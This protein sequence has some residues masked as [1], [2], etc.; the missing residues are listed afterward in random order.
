TVYRETLNTFSIMDNLAQVIIIILP[1]I[2]S[3][4]FASHLF[5]KERLIDKLN[6]VFFILCCQIILVAYAL[7][8]FNAL[9]GNN[10]LVA[11]VVLFLVSLVLCRDKRMSISF[12]VDQIRLYARLL[13]YHL[14][15]NKLLTVFACA[16]IVSLLWRMFLILYVP[17]NTYDSMTYHLARVAYWLQHQSLNS[18]YTNNLRQTVF[19]LNAELLLLWTM[20]ASKIDC[21][22]GFVQFFCYLLSG[23]LIYKCL[24]QYLKT[25]IVPSLSVTFVWYSL[26]EIVL[27]ST[28]TQNDLV[29]SYFL[30]F[31]L[32]YFLCG[33]TDAKKYLPVSAIALAIAIGTKI[34]AVFFL[35]PFFMVLG[36]FSMSS[37]RHAKRMFLWGATF[38]A[39]FMVF[40]APIFIRNFFKYH[41]PLVYGAGNHSLMISRSM[42]GFVTKLCE[43][44]Y[45]ITTNQSGLDVYAPGYAH[46]YNTFVSKIS[47]TMFALL[48]MLFGYPG[49]PQYPE[50]HRFEFKDWSFTFT[51]HEDSAF[52]GTIGLV[53]VLLVS[54]IFFAVAIKLLT[55]K[56]KIDSRYFVFAFLFTGYL[57]GLSYFLPWDPWMSRYMITGVLAG[58]PVLAL[59]FNSKI[60]FLKRV[61]SMVVVYSLMI[62][63]PATLL[64]EK[65]PLYKLRNDKLAL[66]CIPSLGKE[67]IV[68]RFNELVPLHT[69]IGVVVSENSRDYLLFGEKLQRLLVPLNQEAIKKQKFDFIVAI[70]NVLEKKQELK[71]SIE[72]DYALI[73][74]LGTSE[75]NNEWI[76]Y[77]PEHD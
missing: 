59:L 8:L 38:V 28:S 30:M 71:Q 21:Y 22:C 64:G 42:Q 40:G 15:S 29:V 67:A 77:A 6:M 25:G 50:Y 7:S 12:D 73:A 74:H 62:L 32:V 61:S 55:K 60:I 18:F 35:I 11:A 13:S 16:I 4:F 33:I 57:F 53:M 2:S 3:Y 48:H 63:L 52:F 37:A 26:P 70:T 44:L 27:Q 75:Q 51:L 10:C 66:R 14:K 19:P 54:Y 17:P 46:Y 76:L 34:T 56:I 49:S 58:M 45:A 41:D 23:T 9:S 72:K 39:G 47:A 36:Y 1:L 68:R 24:R 43:H 69:K 20:V 31:S 65:K 5:G